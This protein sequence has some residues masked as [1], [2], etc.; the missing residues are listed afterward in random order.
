[1]DGSGGLTALK[2]LTPRGRSRKGVY[3]FVADDDGRTLVYIP[4]QGRVDFNDERAFD[5]P[6]SDK[7][8]RELPDEATVLR[9]SHTA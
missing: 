1:L 9:L 4:Q 8:V 5:G 2:V 3:G 7:K 6:A